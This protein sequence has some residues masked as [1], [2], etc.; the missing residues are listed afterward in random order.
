MGSNDAILSE[1]GGGASETRVCSGTPPRGPAGQ[2]Q[3]QGL[4]WY[5]QLGLM[6]KF[7]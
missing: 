4:D 7:P 1:A 5:D 2:R 6:A 3:S